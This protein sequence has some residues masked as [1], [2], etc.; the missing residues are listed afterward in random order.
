MN[1]TRTDN[2]WSQHAK[3]T[4]F[5]LAVV[6]SDSNTVVSGAYYSDPIST[7]TPSTT[8]YWHPILGWCSDLTLKG[9]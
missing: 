3:L 7:D 8:C 5:D 4:A 9:D 6:S 2:T 1:T